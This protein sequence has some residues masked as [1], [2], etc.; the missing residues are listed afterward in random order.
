MAAARVLYFICLAL[1]AAAGHG[2][3]SNDLKIH[4]V[5]YLTA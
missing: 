3:D 4:T 1:N 5:V 2:I